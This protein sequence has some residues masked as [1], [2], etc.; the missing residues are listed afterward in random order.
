MSITANIVDIINGRCFY[1]ICIVERGQILSIQELEDEHPGIPYLMPGF[2]DAHVH[3]ESSMLVPTEF[4]RLAVRHGTVATVSDP[5]EI[6]NVLGI[7]GVEYML[8][9][10]AQTPLK[11]YFGVPSC[12]PATAFETAGDTIDARAVRKLLQRDELCYL[13]EMMNYPGVLFSD[14]EVMAKI[15]AAKELGKRIDG[16]APGLTGD[17]AIT[18]INAGIS[19]D[20]ECVSYEEA[21]HKVQHGMKIIIRE[22]SAAKN[23][24]ALH[25]LIS[26]YPDMVMLCSDD[27]HPDDLVIG[28][29]NKLVARAIEKG[30]RWQDVLRAACLNPVHHYG[31]KVG[32]LQPGD[33]AD[34]ILT[35]DLR[36]F[37][38]IKTYINGTEVFAD[39]KVILP[40]ASIGVANRFSTSLLDAEA[41]KIKGQSSKDVR[42]IHAIDGALITKEVH[43]WLPVSD[44]GYYQTDTERDILKIT[45]VNRYQKSSP[46]VAFI[47]G[48]GLKQGAIASSVAHDSHNIVAVGVDDSSLIQAI[49]QVISSI[50][51]IVAVSANGHQEVLALPIAGIMSDL[52]GEDVA[53]LYTTIDRFSKD[54]LGSTLKSP[55]MT[56]SFMA[57]LVIPQLKLSDKGLFDGGE[58][59]FIGLEV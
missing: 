4:A 21:L 41:V 59:K 8:N 49:N 57:L 32:M 12:V 51:G 7:D 30:H 29:I 56:L 58:F 43:A 28:H 16:H 55:F 11:F 1:G 15:A 13:A 24:E 45:V 52:P 50:G 5:H 33:P 19:T 23:F 40:E 22:G 53:H 27:K 54:V 39:N 17:A 42:I 38:V 6:A 47:Q 46:A 36:S 35:R 10:A 26:E 34:M 9:N 3:I 25:K 48:F 20:H 37:D 31:L 18:Y 14:S 44:D 2:I